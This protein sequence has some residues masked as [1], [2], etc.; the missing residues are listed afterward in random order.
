MKLCR[1]R[2]SGQDAY[3]AVAN[4][5]V[6]RANG[7]VF[8]TF[9]LTG[10]IYALSEVELLPPCAPSKIVAIGRNYRDHA[11]EFG[12]DV[13]AEPLLFI[14]P[15]T[16]VIATNQPIVLPAIS[17]RVDFEGEVGVIMKKRAFRLRPDENPFDYVLGYTAAL[18]VTARDLQKKDVQFTRAKGFDTFA[19]IG[20]WMETALNPRDIRLQ[21]LVN[22][23]VRQSGSTQQL[24]FPIEHLIRF[25]TDVM[26]LL[27]G[28]VIFTG[29]PAGV[30]P[31][32]PGDRVEV[33]IHELG[34]LSAPVVAQA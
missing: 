24:I 18:D 20:P 4:E 32:H 7:S 29:T 6:Q 5:M 3:G 9:T 10:D 31:L 22:G 34:V 1:F 33:R 8:E 16:A 26:T 2:K 23:E 15:S 17:Q 19:P 25:I 11:K 27:P 12:H 21:T 14:K 13:P 30:G 28:D